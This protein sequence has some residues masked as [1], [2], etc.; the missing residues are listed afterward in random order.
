MDVAR[1]TKR[2]LQRFP[3]IMGPAIWPSASTATSEAE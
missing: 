2:I 1:V 3:M